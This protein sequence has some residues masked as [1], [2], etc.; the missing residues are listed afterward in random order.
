[1]LPTLILLYALDIGQ[2]PVACYVAAWVFT[3]I[4][5]LPKVIKHIRR[6]L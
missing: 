5:Y 4:E 6:F 3:V 1:M 2:I